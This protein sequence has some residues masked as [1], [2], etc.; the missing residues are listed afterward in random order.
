MAFSGCVPHAGCM[1]TDNRYAVPV[2][3][4]DEVR[5]P[6]E[7]QVEQQD[8]HVDQEYLAA[9]ELDRARL[10]S[11]SGAGRLRVR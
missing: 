3:A 10:L 5:V 4:L 8:V 11:T 9:E 6:V 7:Q 2:A 1:T